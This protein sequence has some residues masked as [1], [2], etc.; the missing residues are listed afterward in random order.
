[1]TRREGLLLIDLTATITMFW[2][3]AGLPLVPTLNSIHSRNG[4]YFATASV[5]PW[6][7]HLLSCR[8]G[9]VSAWFAVG[10]V[11]SPPALS[12]CLC[13]LGRTI[14]CS[15]TLY[16]ALLGGQ[17]ASVLHGTLSTPTCRL[18]V[19]EHAVGDEGEGPESSGSTAMPRPVSA[20]S[21]LGKNRSPWMMNPNGIAGYTYLSLPRLW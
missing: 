17:G 5:W 19:V 14:T 3:V 8:R 2:R 1:M 21:S 13:S 6:P 10:S 12:T 15:R 16:T 4:T 18:P 9:E 7:G 11:A 20:L